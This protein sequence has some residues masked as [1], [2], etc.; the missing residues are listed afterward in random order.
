MASIN[1]IA[2][3]AA[4]DETAL[5]EREWFTLAQLA[6]YTGFSRVQLCQVS[7]RGELRSYNRGGRGER[8]WRK[9]DV[10]RWLMGLP[11]DGE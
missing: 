1:R 7:Q 4:R 9:A 5:A 11:P 8:R 3:S 10:D 6:D 2:A